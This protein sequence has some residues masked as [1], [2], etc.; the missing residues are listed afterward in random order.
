[1]KESDFHK[2]FT[3]P[4]IPKE[5]S[6]ADVDFH[7]QNT[8]PGLLKSSTQ[9][10]DSLK[11]PEKIGPY[12]IESLLEKGGMSILYLGT[13]PD[14]KE[15]T[16]IKVLSPRY[17]E[18]P[19]MVKRFLYEAQIISMTD[20][21]NIVKL[22]GHGDWEGGLY[23][24]M[25]FIEGI[26]L[27]QHL[28]RFPLSLKQTLDII[29][30]VA[31]ALCHLHTHGVIHRDLK[32]E[33]ILIT[34]NGVI[35]LIDFGIAQLLTENPAEK[36]EPSSSLIGTPIYMSPEQREFPEKVSYPSD[37]YSLGIIAYELILGKLCHGKV[38][39]SLV[40][41]GLQPILSNMLQLNPE[42]RYR[43]V[44]DLIG[45]LS[46]YMRTKSFVNESLPTDQLSELASHLKSSEEQ[47]LPKH[48]PH[49]Q[50]LTV[51][52]SM[53]KGLILSGLYYD[54]LMT[55]EKDC[56]FL[57]LQPIN[58][59]I[60]TIIA[61]AVAR[62]ILKCLTTQNL[63]LNDLAHTLNLLIVN[64]ALMQQF[65]FSLIV[66]SPLKKVIAYIL[67]SGVSAW[68]LNEANSSISQLQTKKFLIGTPISSPLEFTTI[69][70]VV[71]EKIVIT[72]FSAQSN[73]SNQGDLFIE[74]YLLN[75]LKENAHFPAQ[76]LVDNMIR[77]VRISSS[78]LLQENSILAVSFQI[79]VNNSWV[80][81]T[82]I[83]KAF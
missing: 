41:K 59:G 11:I 49:W 14:T 64:D 17:L 50:G 6:F 69:P 83:G 34:K 13:H 51:G 55:K 56:I 48:A 52:L 71:G 73:E 2:Q 28:L 25:E 29:I 15:P 19:E 80:Q 60:E 33:N 27:R 79:V 57:C 4:G 43:D 23:I 22:F 66:I 7:K 31:Y 62:G 39:I 46:N 40:P 72:S 68:H 70:L 47:L 54:F 24:A 10:A 38:H 16:A 3:T 58:K 26:S 53:H 65:K 32:P 45:D 44:V 81:S 5:H 36:V 61:T 63:S 82:D 30:D 78:K 12:K 77:K 9:E 67:S 74:D 18:N 42:N 35:K 37:I 76:K 21:P 8:L 20:H 1:M 75:A